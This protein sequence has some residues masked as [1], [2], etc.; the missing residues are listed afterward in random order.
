MST[1]RIEQHLGAV[2]D[3]AAIGQLR[4][5]GPR[6]AAWLVAAGIGT[7][8]ELRRLG[9]VAAFRRVRANAAAGVSLNLLWAM[10]AGLL[11]MHWT[12]LPAD[13]KSRLLNE[14]ERPDG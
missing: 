2:A 9:A 1:T 5:L 10:A 14:L 4:N 11:D 8:G 6:S 3:A 12:H 7:V 13:I